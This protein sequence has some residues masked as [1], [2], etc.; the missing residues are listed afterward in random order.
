MS[1]VKP[2][3]RQDTKDEMHLHYMTSENLQLP[4][5]EYKPFKPRIFQNRILQEIRLQKYIH[6]YLY[7]SACKAIAPPKTEG[8]PQTEDEPQK[9]DEPQTEE[10]RE[11]KGGPHQ[12]E[13]D[14]EKI[15]IG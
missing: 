6:Y 14:W 7:A 10:D 5:L 2:L 8:K 9:E 11:K 3:L 13:D 1:P 4:R 15:E 12:A